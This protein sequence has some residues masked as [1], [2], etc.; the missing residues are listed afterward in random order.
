M[1]TLRGS[2]FAREIDSRLYC[3]TRYY[4]GGGRHAGNSNVTE[5]GD[6]GDGERVCRQGAGSDGGPLRSGTVRG[7]SPQTSDVSLI[8]HHRI[9]QCYLACIVSDK[10]S[11]V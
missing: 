10:G 2:Q 8:Q 3:R 1:T 11:A 9:D 4:A 6:D 5:V 7:D